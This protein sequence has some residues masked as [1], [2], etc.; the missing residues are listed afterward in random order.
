M[1]LV[2]FGVRSAGG[3]VED[4]V[5]GEVNQLRVQ[6]PAGHGQVADR[7]GVGDEGGLRFIF[8]DVHLIVGGG[9][10]HQRGVGLS[11]DA[12]DAGGIADIDAG[13]V[14]TGDVITAPGEFMHEF[15]AELSPAAKDDYVALVH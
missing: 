6:L 11:Q 12:F 7:E 1:R 8:G 3:A 15:H 2:F 14:E 9:V 13:A 10:Q 5:G 4:V